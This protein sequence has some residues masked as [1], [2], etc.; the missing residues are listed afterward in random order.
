MKLKKGDGS[1]KNRKKILIA[2][3]ILLLVYVIGVV[4]YV[5]I[6]TKESPWGVRL[7]IED[8]SKSGLTLHMQRDAKEPD[9]P[10]ILTGESFWMEKW[11]PFGWKIVPRGI[12][13]IALPVE[14][15]YQKT[16][17]V[18]FEQYYGG[19]S[20]GLYRITKDTGLEG[21]WFNRYEWL[22]E[23]YHPPFYHFTW[24][25]LLVRCVYLALLMLSVWK[26]KGFRKKRRAEGV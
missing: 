14:P 17:E 22:E 5:N 26:W 23:T 6:P 11:T 4:T 10:T 20:M 15:T 18:D 3:V 8:L 7:W 9:A 12:A 2:I 1:M 21:D 24:W 19:L 13:D 16:W 25:G